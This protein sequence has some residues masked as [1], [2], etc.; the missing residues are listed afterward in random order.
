VL[1]I[2]YFFFFAFLL[3][4]YALGMLCTN[5]LSKD[6]LCAVAVHGHL[7]II[8]YLPIISNISDK[9]YLISLTSLGSQCLSV[10]MPLY[11]FLSWDLV[12]ILLVT[13]LIICES[14]FCQLQISLHL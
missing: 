11:I 8:N 10:C 1:V 13:Q 3:L 9:I 2:M 14:C 4:L 12:L 7:T 5:I 6:N